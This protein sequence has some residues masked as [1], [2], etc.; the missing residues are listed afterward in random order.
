MEELFEPPDPS[1]SDLDVSNLLIRFEILETLPGADGLFMEELIAECL[2]LT[3][4]L[5]PL[6]NAGCLLAPLT[7][8]S[9]DL[10]PKPGDFVMGDFPPEKDFDSL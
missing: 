4:A 8:T 2:E 1:P 5:P 10:L 6:E 9:G 3:P 7:G